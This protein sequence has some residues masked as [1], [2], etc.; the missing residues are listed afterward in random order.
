MELFNTA[1]ELV[2]EKRDDYLR[3]TCGPDHE[4]LQEVRSLLAWDAP[5]SATTHATNPMELDPHG[6][7]PLPERIGPYEIRGLL[8]A[9]GMAVVYRAH[10]SHPDRL[11]ALKV[12]RPHLAESVSNLRFRREINLL[13]RLHHPGIAQIYDAGTATC[14]GTIVQYFAM[15]LI[16]GP[17]LTSYADAR[18]LDRNRRLQLLIQVCDAVEYA[19]RHGIIHR[20][21]KPA[22]I[23]VHQSDEASRPSVLDFGIARLLESGDTGAAFVT[24][25]HHVLGTLAYMSPEQLDPRRIIDARCDEYALG[26]IGYQLLCG[27]TPFELEGLSA[28]AAVPPIQRDPMPSLARVDASCPRDLSIIF[29]KTLSTDPDARYPSVAAFADD[30]RAFLANRPIRARAPSRM[31]LFRKF[32]QRNPVAVP[33][34]GLALMAMLA[35]TAGTIWGLVAARRANTA[36]Q[37]ELIATANSARF[38][39]RDVVTGLDVVAG[40][41]EVRRTLLER[42]LAQIE[43]LRRRAPDDPELAEDYATVLTHVAGVQGNAN[44]NEKELALCREALAVRRWLVD[45]DPVD[46]PRRARLS[47]A[48]VRVG[49]AY[50]VKGDDRA[51]LAIYQQALEIDRALVMEDPAS[52]WYLDN[53]AWSYDRIG[54]LAMKAGNLAEAESCFADRL[55]INQELLQLAPQHAAT[56]HG[57]AAIH[58]LLAEIAIKRGDQKSVAEHRQ[59]AWTSAKELVEEYPLHPVYIETWHLASRDMGETL[60]LSGR[61]AEAVHYLDDSLQAAA[62]LHELDPGS[63][64]PT[65]L[66]LDSMFRRAKLAM[67]LRDLECADH[68][69]RAAGALVS[70]VSAKFPDIEGLDYAQQVANLVADLDALRRIN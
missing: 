21:L 31:Y 5:T 32:T 29:D 4:L 50:R 20:D 57:I 9:G 35:G 6:A 48:L 36:L 19:H 44:D 66:Y 45:L 16:E 40:T 69:L 64:H 18:S 70:T 33:L 51:A 27:R 68:Y 8:G 58:G 22:N 56:R 24:A 30:L 23:L 46:R 62:Q 49:D 15:E 47:L 2:T 7:V 53:L 63:V 10:Q 26:V 38:L 12:L 34:A 17:P 14:G 28:R 3:R 60:E 42:L 61:L 39:V 65:R 11:V 54:Y 55:A 13:A 59:E 52:R 1:A 41:A 37:H 43:A 25:E 67:K